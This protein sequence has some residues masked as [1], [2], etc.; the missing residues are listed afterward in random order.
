MSLQLLRSLAVT[1]AMALLFSTIADAQSPA[2]IDANLSTQQ[3]ELS[4]SGQWNFVWGQWVPT[5]DIAAGHHQAQIITLPNYLA[6]LPVANS[7]ASNNTGIMTYFIKIKNLP[8][9]FLRPTVD[10]GDISEAWEAW[11]VDTSGQAIF[12][13][14]SGRIATT[15]TQQEF[16]N[17]N[18]LLSLPNNSREG[19]LVFYVSA[20][21]SVRTGLYSDI[22]IAEYADVYKTAI[23]DLA[24][25]AFILG[26]GIYII[27]Q[28]LVFFVQ[29]PK[30]RTLLL[31]AIFAFTGL[32]RAAFASGY[33][34][35]FVPM[36]DFHHFS[37]R[38]EYLLIVWPAV[39]GLHMLSVFFPF[40][41]LRYL[42][43]LG[44]VFLFLLGLVT[45]NISLTTMTAYLGFYQYSLAFFASF[46]LVFIFRG[47]IL[48]LPNARAFLF[49]FLPLIAAILN[50]V[51]AS[52]SAQYSFYI[53]EYAFFL[54]MFIQTQIQASRFI[55]ALDTAEHLTTNLQNEV[56]RQTV[57][58]QK[59]NTLLEEKADS[60]ELKHQEVKLLSETDHLTGLYNRQSLDS[61]FEHHFQLARQSGQPLSLVMMDL[62][63]FKAINDKYGHTVGDEC[64]VFAASYLRGLNLRKRDLIARYGGEEFVIL[65][66]DTNLDMATRVVQEICDG[67][68]RHPVTGQHPDIYLTASFG[69]AELSVSRVESPQMLIE[70]ADAALYS[71]KQKGRN[72]V[73][74]DI[75]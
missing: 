18:Y 70:R 51:Y 72:R 19:Y 73:E 13:G 4:L 40:P 57:E 62:D 41:A 17:K 58:L 60:L 54:F 23:A 31:L 56:D 66:T 15:K 67:L 45:F 50:D 42:P 1:V 47:L 49:S 26:I 16:N 29:R 36:V 55:V 43:G 10:V 24:S 6:D 44:Y 63:H 74:S 34:D 38:F 53:A 71:A 39:A 7:N 75:A 48:R 30:E 32:L 9:V 20:Y 28:N 52:R 11:W 35:F 59:R 3:G 69:I 21:H 25:R 46:C 5:D 64:L 37:L 22:T 61:R 65:L 12:L 68:P 8:D 14:R 2:E 33:V 27:T